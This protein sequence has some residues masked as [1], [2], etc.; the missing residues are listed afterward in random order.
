MEIR[1]AELIRFLGQYVTQHKRDFIDRVLA[2][3]TKYVTL[4][5][6]D[7]YQSQNASAALRTCECLGVQD[8]HIIENTSTYGTNKKVLKGSHKW[9]TINRYKSKAGSS[10]ES[11]IRQLKETGYR[12]IATDPSPSGVSLEDLDVTH[13]KIAFVMGNEQHGTSPVV[14]QLADQFV[15]IPMFGFTESFN[16]SV[17]AALCLSHTLRKVRS[18]AVDWKLTSQEQED[19]RLAWYKKTIR[20]AELIEQEY[21]KM[22]R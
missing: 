12:I 16:I 6:E 18:S 19:L 10:T 4:V 8:I 11:C 22:N 9:L 13:G 14:A 5:L 17:S 15:Y 21:L 20:R 3:R 7:I 1:Q 2:Q